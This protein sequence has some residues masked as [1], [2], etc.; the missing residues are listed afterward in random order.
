[1]TPSRQAD[2]GNIFLWFQYLATHVLWS[3]S[4]PAEVQPWEVRSAH[5]CRAHARH[6]IHK[7]MGGHASHGHTSDRVFITFQF[8]VGTIKTLWPRTHISRLLFNSI[9]VQ[10][11]HLR[12]NTVFVLM[13]NPQTSHML[14]FPLHIEASYSLLIRSTNS[15]GVSISIFEKPNH[16]LPKSLMDAPM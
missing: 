8:R 10:L 16:F 13:R 5:P 7:A 14:N 11:E 1:M 15:S 2:N 12:V 4:R 6:P 3:V 9:M